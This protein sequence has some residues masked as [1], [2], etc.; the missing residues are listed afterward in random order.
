MRGILIVSSLVVFLFSC[1]KKIKTD[2]LEES[3]KVSVVVDSIGVVEAIKKEPKKRTTNF[4][5]EKFLIEL[6]KVLA[7]KEKNV[8]GVNIDTINLFK[9]H[10]KLR[11]KGIMA[12][13]VINSEYL[14]KYT[15]KSNRM[16][17]DVIESQNSEG[18]QLEKSF[19][20]LKSSA[21]NKNDGPGLTYENDY[22]Q[23]SD[24]KLYW[25]NTPCMVSYNNHLLLSDFFV[26][27]NLNLKEIYCKCGSVIC[28]M[29]R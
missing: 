10:P 24:G 11:E 7:L 29:N 8:F 20:M 13:L 26:K 1:N 5:A 28:D 25:L 12:S 23:L 6:N 9:L 27:E 3:S 21:M 16:A 17:I 15:F 4:D 2:D 19:L 18:K 22:V 14:I